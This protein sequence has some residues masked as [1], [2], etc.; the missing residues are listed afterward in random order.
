MP[1]RLRSAIGFARD[2]VRPLGRFPFTVIGIATLALFPVAEARIFP[3][4]VFRLLVLPVYLM[5]FL[6]VALE[7]AIWGPGGGPRILDSLTLPLLLAPYVVLD[8]SVEFLLRG[9]RCW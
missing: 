1:R 2:Y 7:V 3:Q 9:R 6:I 4:E 8:L 5:R